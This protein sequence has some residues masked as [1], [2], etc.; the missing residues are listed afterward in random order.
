[1]ARLRAARHDDQLTLVEHLDELRTR[2]VVS[3]LAFG[4][5]FALCFWQDDL[6][7]EIANKPLPGD[8]QPITFAVAEPF[9]TTLTVAAYGAILLALPV[10]LYQAYAYVLPALSPA[11]KRTVLPFALAV[12]VLFVAG[13][14]LGYFVIMPAATKFLLEF[15]ASE[16]TIEVRAREY[17]GFLGMVLLALGLLFQLPI[18]IL[19]VTRLGII[20]A[21]D[22]ASRRRYAIVIIAV[23]SAALP[24][25]DPVSM[26]LIMIPLLA[27]FEGSIALARIFERRAIDVEP[28]PNEP[29]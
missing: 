13:V 10:V 18:G 3:G 12:P 14:A 22:L 27:L 17:Y 5:A 15:N 20:S 21:D 26:M 23:V 16:F 8:R 11:E 19:S 4:V 24:G 6:L 29:T 25:G 7:L 9:L 2:I 28:A 1:M